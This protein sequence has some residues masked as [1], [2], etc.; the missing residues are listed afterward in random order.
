MYTN[1]TRINVIDLVLAVIVG[2]FL[3]ERLISILFPE[4]EREIEIESDAVRLTRDL[5]KYIEAIVRGGGGSHRIAF[6]FE[7]PQRDKNNMYIHTSTTVYDKRDMCVRRECRLQV[8]L[9]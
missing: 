3:T 8:D 7:I 9:L 5:R 2:K 6:S 4:G 1:S